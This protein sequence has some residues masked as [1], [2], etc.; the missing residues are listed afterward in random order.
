MFYLRWF[1]SKTLREAVNFKRH[2]HKLLRHQ[3]DV[4]TPQAVESLQGAITECDQAIRSGIPASQLRGE[5]HKLERAANKWLK[6][7]PNASWR[8][9]V[10]M[11]LVALAVA[12]AI[13]TFWLQPFKIPTGSM[14]PTLFGVTSEPDYSKKQRTADIMK[15]PKAHCVC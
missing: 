8:E 4:L 6:P 9:N 3:Q 1:L 11:L 13:R 5:M 15:A 12:M 2:V 7:Y 10:E 14:Q